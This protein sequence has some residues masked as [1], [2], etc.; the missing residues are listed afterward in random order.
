MTLELSHA[1]TL[2]LK[3]ALDTYLHELF[4]EISR[5]DNFDFR[6]SLV[7]THERLEA[8]RRRLEG[9]PAPSGLHA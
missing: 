1:E 6:H 8:I 3:Q 5:T 4:V 9:Q 7:V 2:E